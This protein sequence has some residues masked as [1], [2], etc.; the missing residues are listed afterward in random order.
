MEPATTTGLDLDAYLER[1]RYKGELTPT[2]SV[3]EALHEAHVSNIPF[4]NLDIFLGRPILLDL[5]SLQAKLVR[6]RRGGYCFEHN[7][8]FSAV[9][10]QLGF[11]VTRLS[12]R[13]RLGATRVLARTHMLLRVDIDGTPWLA[14]VGFG[15]EG[16]LRPV[17]MALDQKITHGGRRYRIAADTGVWVLQF[18]KADTWSDIYAFTQEPQHLVDYELANYYIST[19]PHSI[20]TRTLTAQ[21]VTRNSRA[22]LRNQDLII[23]TAESQ[24]QRTVDDPDELLVVLAETFGLSFPPGTRFSFTANKP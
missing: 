18:S 21:R 13:V 20:F 10:E 1:L 6:G 7:L 23:E 4:E 22:I 2:L 9:L 15:G 12:A 19:H 17:P 14:D 11:H 8:L 16:L 24:D 3:L 5:E